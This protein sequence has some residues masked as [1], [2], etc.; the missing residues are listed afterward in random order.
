MK[1]RSKWQHRIF[2]FESREYTVAI[3][4]EKICH[5]MHIP[6]VDSDILPTYV[7][8]S[9]IKFL[10]S[11]KDRERIE[12]VLRRYLNQKPL[13]LNSDEY[14]GNQRKLMEDYYAIY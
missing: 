1:I 11:K 8:H 2:E 10:A 12:Y 14:Q 5:N 7:D 4:F 13:Y 9:N 3:A 6:I